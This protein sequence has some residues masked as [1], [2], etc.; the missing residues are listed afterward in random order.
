MSYL[1]L[2]KFF[3]GKNQEL[4]KGLFFTVASEIKPTAPITSST[5]AMKMKFYKYWENFC[6]GEHFTSYNDIKEKMIKYEGESL[7]GLGFPV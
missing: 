1:F 2:N 6:R 3:P 5:R 7:A 4:G